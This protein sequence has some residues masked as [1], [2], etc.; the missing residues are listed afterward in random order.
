MY[1]RLYLA[2]DNKIA[3][4]LLALS[5]VES[6]IMYARP[7]PRS[8]L[9]SLVLLPSP[10]LPFYVPSPRDAIFFG[11]FA[12]IPFDVY[13]QEHNVATHVRS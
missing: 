3:G 4:I 6:D 12:V 2:K 5:N 10:V 13:F 9:S 11:K 8:S 7:K 1:P